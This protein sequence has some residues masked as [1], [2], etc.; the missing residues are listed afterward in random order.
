M[1]MPL[2]EWACHFASFTCIFLFRV[3]AEQNASSNQKDLRYKR[4]HF[5]LIQELNKIIFRTHVGLSASP[6]TPVPSIFLR[7]RQRRHA[8][9]AFGRINS[10]TWFITVKW[11]IRSR[12]VGCN[13]HTGVRNLHQILNRLQ[14]LRRFWILAQ[15]CTNSPHSP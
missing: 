4:V 1:S 8:R 2:R 3:C 14:L 9:S 12:T 11:D 6:S 5:T 10:V 15:K 7:V 13:W